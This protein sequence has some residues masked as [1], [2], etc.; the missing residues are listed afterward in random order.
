MRSRVDIAIA[1]AVAAVGQL[2]VWAPDLMGAKVVGSRP[3]VAAFYLVT[4]LALAWRR[5]AP[6]AVAM[7][8]VGVNVVQALALGTSEGQGVLIPGLIALYSVGAHEDRPRSLVP[9]AFL[10]FVLLARE[11]NNP[12]NTDLGHLLDALAWES[13]IFAAWLLGAYLR[14]RRLYV[15]ELQERTVRAELAREEQA[16][17]AVANE[18]AR[19]ARELHDAVAHGVTV[20]VVQAEAAEEMLGGDPERARQPLRKVQQ[21][22]REALVELRRLLGLLREEEAEALRG[23]QP[24]VAELDAL[25][26]DVEAAGLPV[27]LRVEGERVELPSGMDLSAYRIV[28][29]ALTNALKHAGPASATVA[30]TYGDGVLDL[31]ITDDGV[32]QA[33]ANGAGHGLAGMR[34]RVALYGGE[35]TSGPRPDGGYAVRARLPVQR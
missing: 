5:R 34:E 18:R 7:L 24:G 2:E 26:A 35:L 12:D 20:M 31:E 27:E 1:L 21:T 15:A 6:F 25:I 16:R 9:L 17:A 33:S 30:L 19:I 10:A 29:E 4:A 22:G 8:V 13:T 28:Q 3:V 14:T 23:P 32:G 11:T